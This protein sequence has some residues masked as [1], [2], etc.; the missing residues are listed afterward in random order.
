MG[1]IFADFYEIKDL[2]SAK[3]DHRRVKRAIKE[4]TFM[5]FDATRRSFS[6]KINELFQNPAK[7]NFPTNT[8]V[9]LIF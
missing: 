4:N 2:F 5:Q 8:G 7:R 3:F 6:H 1:V 9:W